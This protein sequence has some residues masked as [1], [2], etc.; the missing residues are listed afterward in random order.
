M[1]KKAFLEKEEL[2]RVLLEILQELGVITTVNNVFVQPNTFQPY[3][4]PSDCSI[5][6]ATRAAREKRTPELADSIDYILKYFGE[7]LSHNTYA[8]HSRRTLTE[9]L[10]A[11]TA[12]VEELVNR[13]SQN[14]EERLLK[15]IQVSGQA[16]G[17]SDLETAIRFLIHKAQSCN[18]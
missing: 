4:T 9:A 13:T 10:D 16:L 14:R 18:G 6:D 2:K 12:A 5:S 17:A 7:Y 15:Q 1:S 11:A 8:A 3:A